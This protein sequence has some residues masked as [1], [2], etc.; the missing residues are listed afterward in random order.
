MENVYA[1]VFILGSF[2]VAWSLSSMSCSRKD[3]QTWLCRCIDESATW[4]GRTLT[5]SLFYWWAHQSL[6]N[7]KTN[8]NIMQSFLSISLKYN[9][10]NRL[11]RAILKTV[12]KLIWIC[13]WLNSMVF[14]SWYLLFVLWRVAIAMSLR[15]S[16]SFNNFI[17]ER[18]CFVFIVCFP[19]FLFWWQNEDGNKKSCFCRRV[20]K[21]CLNW[22]ETEELC[23]YFISPKFAL[24]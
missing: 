3:S 15:C 13:F 7:S 4:A 21:W 12:K 5:I 20:F 8:M 18:I 22:E 23:W 16:K 14:L 1:S 17:A 19:A 9:L 2:L 11:S 10:R 6:C 24:L